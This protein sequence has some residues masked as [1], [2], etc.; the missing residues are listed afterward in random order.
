[1]PAQHPLTHGQAP[2][3]PRGRTAPLRGAA[4]RG[5]ADSCDRP[6]VRGGLRGRVYGGATRVERERFESAVAVAAPVRRG[7][8]ASRPLPRRARRAALALALPLALAGCASPD[9]AGLV[10]ESA[11]SAESASTDPGEGAA[12][13]TA[14]KTPYSALQSAKTANERAQAGPAPLLPTIDRSSLP[15]I[16]LN[17]GHPHEVSVRLYANASGDYQLRVPERYDLIEGSTLGESVVEAPLAGTGVTELVYVSLVA[18]TADELSCM[19][20]IDGAVVDV[21]RS[22]S[23]VVS[24]KFTGTRQQR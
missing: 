13:A 24:C 18:V 2:S 23:G 1:M 12:P 4:R 14:T 20:S 22:D 3:M 6:S 15:A 16:D 5:A 21:Q 10:P 19:I 9:T 7:A 11:G 17:D 8:E